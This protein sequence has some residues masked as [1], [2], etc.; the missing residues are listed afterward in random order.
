MT[1]KRVHIYCI[2]IIALAS[3]VFI[4]EEIALYYGILSVVANDIGIFFM[5]APVIAQILITPITSIWVRMFNEY[6]V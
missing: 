5:A 3:A 1:T 2:A 6:T 4:L